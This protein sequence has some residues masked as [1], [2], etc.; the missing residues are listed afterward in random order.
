MAANY[1]SRPLKNYGWISSGFGDLRGRL[2]PHQGADWPAPTGT[3]IRAIASGR[4]ID[5]GS[6]DRVYGNWVKLRTR[7]GHEY[8]VGHMQNPTKL[9]IG[10]W[11]FMFW[12]IG[13]VGQSGMA[14]GPHCHISLWQKI[15]GRL[16][17]VDPVKFIRTH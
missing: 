5:K 10:A 8:L 7:K 16:V 17:L 6:D 3:V 14:T 9:K 15:N 4:V 2:T 1:A 11:R 12:R 13:F